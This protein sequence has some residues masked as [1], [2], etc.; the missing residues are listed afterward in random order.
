M[1]DVWQICEKKGQTKAVALQNKEDF[2]KQKEKKNNT[3]KTHE[4]RCTYANVFATWIDLCFS[5]HS[6]TWQISRGDYSRAGTDVHMDFRPVRL[7]A[8][9]PACMRA[10]ITQKRAPKGSSSSSKNQPPNRVRVCTSENSKCTYVRFLSLQSLVKINQRLLGYF[11]LLFS[12]RRILG[13]FLSD[14][15]M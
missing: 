8:C 6:K 13:H 12:N 11:L 7:P 3:I 5:C 10:A 15:T 14:H 9:L 4:I 2:T 1:N